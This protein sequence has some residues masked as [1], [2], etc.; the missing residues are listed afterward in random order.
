MNVSLASCL[1]RAARSTGKRNAIHG[2]FLPARSVA[3]SSRSGHLLR[4]SGQLW[5]IGS[6]RSYFWSRGG[7][8]SPEVPKVPE[9][10]PSTP[11]AVETAAVKATEASSLE[12]AAASPVLSND[13]S[14]ITSSPVSS[15]SETIGDSVADVSST[16]TSTL[17]STPIA[18][19]YGDMAALGLVS[20]TPAGF[21]PWLLEAVQV[22]TALPWWGAIVLTT[23]GTRVAL[24]P[25]ILRSQRT[26]AKLAPLQPK[27]TELREKMNSARERGDTL[28]SQALMKQQMALLKK[29]NINPLDSLLT[30]VAQLGAQV[31]FFLGL[32]RMCEV[33]VQS[34]QTGGFGWVTDLAAADPYYVLPMINL[35][36]IQ[37]QLTV[38]KQDMMAVGSPSSLHMINVMRIL[39]LGGAA[40]ILNFPAAVNLHLIASIA[41]IS[42]QTLLLRVPAVR[43]A[44]NLPKLIDNHQKAPT[45]RETKDAAFAWFRVR[46]EEAQKKDLERQRKMNMMQRPPPPP[47]RFK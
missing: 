21:F 5:T 41:F 43:R 32:R 16:V 47:P 23:V 18:T 31:G 19:Q 2:A 38:S 30:A 9:T 6:S 10:E 12:P 20:W 4:S 8:K 14:T 24:L 7:G 40:F 11:N 42:A 34:L 1:V 25:L 46:A 39:S 3:L 26:Q 44:V 37:L 33:P 22:S 29:E 27:M 17:A 45:M 28:E 15:L 13:P 36:L 35:A